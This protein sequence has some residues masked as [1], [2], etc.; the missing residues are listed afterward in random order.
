[1]KALSVSTAS[2]SSEIARI[3]DVVDDSNESIMMVTDEKTSCTTS[4]TSA[5]QMGNRFHQFLVR[6]QSKTHVIS[7]LNNNNGESCVDSMNTHTQLLQLL[8]DRT[9]WPLSYLR[10]SHI[11][12]PFVQVQVCSSIRGG[13]GGFGTLLKGQSRQAGAKMTTDFGACRDLQGR[14]LRHVNDEIKLRKWRE[15]QRKEAAG[16]K[17]ENDD[18]WNTQSGIYNWHLMTPTWAD[19]SKKDTNRIK[20]Q[21][22][23]MDRQL[24]KETALKKEH[25]EMYQ[26]TMTHYLEETTSVSKSVQENLNDAIKQGLKNANASAVSNKKRKRIEGNVTESNTSF[27]NYTTSVDE[28]PNSLVSLSG[29]VAVETIPGVESIKIQSK[30]DFMTAVFVLDRGEE[31]LSSSSSKARILPSSYY[32]ETTLVTGGLAQIGWACLVNRKGS[33]VFAPSND[34]GDGVGDDNDSF[35]V[36]GSRGLKFHGGTESKFAIDWRKGD[37]LGCL[38]DIKTG[39][40]SFT[41]NGKDLGVAFTDTKAKPM[42]PAFSCNQNEILELHITKKDCKYF[43]TNDKGIIAVKDLVSIGEPMTEPRTSD[44]NPKEQ[45]NKKIVSTSEEEKDFK[46]SCS[47]N[48]SGMTDSSCSVRDADAKVTIV[49]EVQESI[50]PK[51]LDL[52]P[53]K[54]VQELEELG[55]GRLKSALLALKVKCGGT[56]QQR[57]ERLFSLKGLDYEDFPKKVRTKGLLSQNEMF[58]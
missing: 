47:Q 50:K 8:A 21:F 4:T 20:R 30:S 29:D 23:K 58:K 25:D 12:F 55:L 49:P 34:L 18:M 53:Y 42:M 22:Q 1:M 6:F 40:M 45:E 3:P 24:E 27:S 35:A 28:Q 32:Y 33:S 48:E 52:D 54:C 38:L 10:I 13:K 41:L 15:R 11:S 7:L 36:D 16:E 9:G 19:I 44:N 5:A 37:R 39:D 2:C 26:K 14:R 51:L 43:P 46:P 17:V 31:S 57:A 56:L